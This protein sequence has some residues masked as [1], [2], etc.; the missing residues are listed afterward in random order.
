MISE[1]LGLSINQKVLNKKSSSRVVST[2]Q[3]TATNYLAIGRMAED[4]KLIRLNFSRWLAMEGVKVKGTPDAH[5][6]KEDELAKKFGV[7]REKYVSSKSPKAARDGAN[8]N[9]VTGKQIGRA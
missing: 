4:L 6:L 7:M 5:M 8:G 2:L 3:K 1:I 9:I